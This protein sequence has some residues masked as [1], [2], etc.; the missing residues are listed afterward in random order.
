M[1]K[2]LSLACILAGVTAG[3]L[4]AQPADEHAEKLANL[5]KMIQL[6]GGAKIIDQMFSAMS[7]QMKDPRQQEILA[8]FQKELDVNEIYNIMIPAWD[9]YLSADDI[10]DTIR[11][12]ESP[13]G[14]RLLDAQPKVLTDS[15]PKIMEWSQQI[16]QRLLEKMKEKGVQ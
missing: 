1:K 12:Y 13:A 11:F 6:T 14:K 7:A 3:S 5:R 16:S 15:M 4:F 8:Q 2:V 10:K 9:K